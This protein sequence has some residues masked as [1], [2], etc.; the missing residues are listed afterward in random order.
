MT[1]TMTPMT[2]AVTP[3]A[4]IHL[5]EEVLDAAYFGSPCKLV[6]FPLSGVQEMLDVVKANHWAASRRNFDHHRHFAG[7]TGFHGRSDIWSF[8]QFVDAVD[9]PWADGLRMF[10]ALKASIDPEA[11][12]RPT[13]RRRR[14]KWGED[15]GDELSID[16]RRDGDPF[17]REVPP[18]RRVGPAVV[19]LSVDVSA[20]CWRLPESLAWRGIVGA[21]LAELLEAAG[22][23]TEIRCHGATSHRN[24]LTPGS[25]HLHRLI[26]WSVKRSSDPLD[27]SALVNVTSG[28][29]FR[30]GVFEAMFAQP[31]ENGSSLGLPANL[32]QYGDL[33]EK[34]VGPGCYIIE[35]AWDKDDAVELLTKILK[36]FSDDQSRGD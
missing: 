19:T 8:Q 27:V 26:D 15:G 32:S 22:Y 1:A 35:E 21:V 14:A 20:A 6:H 3:P 28:W 36:D 25:E 9:R 34:T 2:A 4:R 7:A 10:D 31:R 33:L 12:P 30:I 23:R 17:F 29:F 13:A 5:F 11:L 24:Y 18:A 16:R